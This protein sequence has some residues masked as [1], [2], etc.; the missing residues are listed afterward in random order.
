VTRYDWPHIRL[1]LFAA[2]TVASAAIVS[3]DS[4]R[5]LA[6]YAGF[7]QFSWLFPFTLDA[8]AA[9]GMDLWVRDSPAM[10]RARALAL[11]AIA[12]S[13]VANT[14]DHW[15]STRSVLSAVMGAVPPFMLAALLAVLHQH[16][17]G[18]TADRAQAPDQTTGPWARLVSRL[19]AQTGP[20][21]QY[22]KLVPDQAV[23][24]QTGAG[25]VPDRRDSG[26]SVAKRAQPDPSQGDGEPDP[27]QDAPVGPATVTKLPSP[28][29]SVAARIAK[30]HRPI[31]LTDNDADVLARLAAMDVL[32][33]KRALQ[34]FE[35]CGSSRALR[36]LATAREQRHG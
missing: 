19:R 7:S 32:P 6:I 25:P 33:T 36:L 23:P 35:N 21:G 11:L 4:V 10:R 30:P 15:I 18:Q 8:V 24:D 1:R 12:L 5:R 2:V 28:N 9:F 27:D 34:E 22:V 16:T 14:A 26:P 17:A 31:K 13:L 20:I 29:R 3:F